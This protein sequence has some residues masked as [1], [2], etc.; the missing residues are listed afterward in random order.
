M[1]NPATGIWSSSRVRVI[2][3]KAVVA[4]RIRTALEVRDFCAHAK[5]SRI[6]WSLRHAHWQRE[7]KIILS[8]GPRTLDY[9]LE[10][11]RQTKKGA[12]IERLTSVARLF[13]HA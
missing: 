5:W 11:R 13:L 8:H 10:F 2:M 4:N 6:F 1:Y 7:E 12:E 9:R 3:R